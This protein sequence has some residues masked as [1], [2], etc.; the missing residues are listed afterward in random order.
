MERYHNLKRIKEVFIKKEEPKNIFKNEPNKTEIKLEVKDKEEQNF[1]LNVFQ[2][3]C[4]IEIR[5]KKKIEYGSGFFIK[6]PIGNYPFYC[7]MTCEHVVKENMIEKK[8]V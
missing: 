5:E 4:K 7:L 8:K 1:I 3:I 2:S 6:L